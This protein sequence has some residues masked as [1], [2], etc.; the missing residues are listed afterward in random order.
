MILLLWALLFSVT[1]QKLNIL[2]TG[3]IHGMLDPCDCQINPGGGIA[4]CAAIID[5]VACNN[6]I[7]VLDAGGFSAGGMYDEYTAG[8]VADSLRTVA[9]IAALS[10]IPYQAIVLGD[11]ELQRDVAGFVNLCRQ[12]RLPIVSC[13]V[14]MGDSLIAPPYIVKNIQG[15]RIAITGVTTTEQ[16][17]LRDPQ[18]R[19][20][21][22]LLSLRAIFPRMQQEA[23]AIVLLSH[24]GEEATVDLLDSLPPVQ[25][26][27]IGHRKKSTFPAAYI[28]AT[29]ALFFGYQGKQIAA[30]RLIIDSLPWHIDTAQ[31][32]PVSVKGNKRQEI[33]DTIELYRSQITLHT[34]SV[35]DLYIMSLC[36]FG[37]MGLK[38]L[39]SFSA[40]VPKIELNVWFIGDVEEHNLALHSLH[41]DAEIED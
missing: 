21:N 32:I 35:Y 23:D 41:G 18:V 16:V 4:R 22:P 20:H 10:G 33:L 31:Y 7:L 25:A 5:S 24:L 29:P 9:A 34:K 30:S 40:Q 37:L 15:K 36:P 2:A 28:G 26:V 38:E 12:Y 13:N 19:V 17:L 6:S 1:A 11:E 39:L 14:T 27:V 8:R 3:E